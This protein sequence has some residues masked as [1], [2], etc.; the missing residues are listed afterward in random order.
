MQYLI[1]F[2]LQIIIYHAVF[3]IVR[4]TNNIVIIIIIIYKYH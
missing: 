2:A 1:L 4:F 3:N